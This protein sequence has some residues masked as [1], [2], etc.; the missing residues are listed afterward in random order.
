MDTESTRKYSVRC[1]SKDG[2][3]V[4]IHKSH[5]EFII[6]KNPELIQNM[7]KKFT[8]LAQKMIHNKLNVGLTKK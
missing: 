5:F 4:S 7:I 2:V 1:T 6:R 8:S 3:L